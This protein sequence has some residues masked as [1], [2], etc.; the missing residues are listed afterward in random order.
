[1]RGNIADYAR[2]LETQKKEFQD[3]TE[4]QFQQHKLVINELIASARKEF[5]D[6]HI[7]LNTLH[8]MTDQALKDV[9]KKINELEGDRSGGGAGHGVAW[10]SKGYIPTK[11]LVPKTFTN[12]EEDW[13]RW[14]DDAMDYF[15]SLN[16]GMKDLLKEVE[17]EA[18]P[19][20]N[21]WLEAQV[22]DARVKGDQVQLWRA[23]KNLTDGEA[24]KVVTSVK[25]ENGFRAWQKLHQRFGPSLSSKQ[26]L[27][28]MEFSGMVAK[29]A[30][31]PTETRT[32]VTEMEQRIKLVEDITGTEVSENHVKS[33]LVGI[34]DPTTRQH[35]AMYHGNKYTC[36]E[37]KRVILEFV[38]N[39]SR[40][41]DN[42][43]QVGRVSTEEDYQ[44]DGYGYDDNYDDTYLGAMGAGTQCY[45][46]LGYGHI[47]V[48]C[49]LKGKG[50]GQDRGQ[51]PVYGKAKGKGWSEV[52]KG[53][54]KGFD[55]A[56]GTKGAKGKG[57]RGPMYGTCWTC[58]GDHFQASCPKGKGKGGKGVYALEEEWH[59]EEAHGAPNVR[60]LS[61]F[62]EVQTSDGDVDADRGWKLVDYVK[63]KTKQGQVKKDRKQQRQQQEQQQQ[64]QRQVP[65][66]RPLKT[67]EPE[68]VNAI[69]DSEWEEID[70]AVDSGASETVIGECMLAGV[71]TQEGPA[72][73]RGVQYEVANGIRIP[74]L[75]EKHFRGYTDEGMPRTLKAQV[76]EVNKA[77]LSVSKLVQM[78]NRVV[79][80]S[81]GS[82]IED[83][84]TKEKMWLREQG[85]MY[86]LKMWVKGKGF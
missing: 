43:M 86:M 44:D 73:K 60:A 1:M 26:G 76:C 69:Q 42:A 30:K 77:L 39:V 64:T 85:G 38:N 40:R 3:N 75:G 65:G 33:V 2:G 9:N 80:D 84:T 72:S 74:N 47:A 36:D 35:T 51:A 34:L 63:T 25:E 17:L 13:R 29:P 27:V 8:G 49:P 12:K 55:P 78:G 4:I 32:L 24:R 14:Q 61:T 50:K 79:F 48:N 58:G 68:E 11:S 41:D 82:Y 81:Q 20:D 53:K 37:L 15:D 52:P 71:E 10:K 46:C 57:K 45:S 7:N 83:Q 19:V 22:H 28:L 67:I 16:E 6:L 62:N 18:R 23:L 5:G 56:K 59:S 21:A 66:L 70:L 31:T 54:G